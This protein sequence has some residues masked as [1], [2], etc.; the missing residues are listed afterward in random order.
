MSEQQRFEDTIIWITGA[1]SGIGETLAKRLAPLGSRLILSARRMNE[2]ERV[3]QACGNVKHEITLLPFDLSS[4]D[5]SA[6]A[7]DEV[8]AMFNTVDY[9]FNNGGISQRTSVL[10]TSLEMDRKI[11]EVNYF[12][13][14]ILTKKVL[15]AMLKKGHGHII[16]I[17][18]ISGLF[19][20]P[21]RTAYCAS[22]HAVN[23]FYEA[24][25]TELQDKGIRTTVI[26][27][28]RIKTNISFH[29]LDKGGKPHGVMDKAQEEGLSPEKCVGAII[30]GIRKN[31][32]MVLIGRKEL[33]PAYLKRYIPALFYWLI[34]K[35]KPT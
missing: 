31:R 29:A 7:A 12:S 13:G 15:P 27:P 19:G 4:P 33:I 30:R 9:L 17:S 23:G 28:G 8:L 34:I 35:I 1:S 6:R 25:W 26:L 5:E 24:V 22:K 10:D 21:L 14:I 3:K 16:A 11:M 2:L 20:F 18:S 32:R